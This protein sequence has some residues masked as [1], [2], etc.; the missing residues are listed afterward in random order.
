MQALAS[1]MQLNTVGQRLL[2]IEGNHA[3]TDVVRMSVRMRMACADCHMQV[4]ATMTQLN[5]AGLQ[6]SEMQ[7]VHAMTDVTGFGLAG[8]L[9]E[10]ARGSG[11]AACVD[12]AKVGRRNNTV[13]RWGGFA[14]YSSFHIE[15]CSCNAATQRY[16]WPYGECRPPEHARCIIN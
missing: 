7:G 9:L 2:E 15:L 6:L 10:V 12:F 16:C 5:K 1:T 14:W 3:I 4:L 11:L 8:H 13:K